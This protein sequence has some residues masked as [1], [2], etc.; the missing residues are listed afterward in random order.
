M[1]DMMTSAD[2]TS[3]GAASQ[4]PEGIVA[5]EATM[6]TEAAEPT[7][8]QQASFEAEAQQASDDAAADESTSDEGQQSKAP[9]KYEFKPQ[10][11]QEFDSEVIDAFA[12]VAKE[13]DLSQ[14]DA[15]KVLDRV[16]PKMA[17]RQ[18]AMLDQVRQEWADSA[19]ADKEYGGEKLQE[20]LAV[21]KKALDQFGTPELRELLESSGLGNNPEVI[22]FM[23]R[24][25]KAISEDGYVGQ[26]LGAKGP[27]SRPTDF[28]GFA[29]Y[30][31]SNQSGA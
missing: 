6:V 19:M 5:P 23:V 14:E 22:R 7:G 25:G 12:D 30:L 2:Q 10:D 18:Q 13:L 1:T 24:T 20:N 3:D 17:E 27:K 4:A 21:A 29:E 8:E 9:E 28:N 15:Q 11:G 31:Y 26:D 16:G